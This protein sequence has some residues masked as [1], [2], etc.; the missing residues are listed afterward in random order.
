MPNG[1]SAL[2]YGSTPETSWGGYGSPGAQAEA[3]AEHWG[4]PG[5]YPGGGAWPYGEIR[6]WTPFWQRK[7]PVSKSFF[8]SPLEFWPERIPSPPTQ[9]AGWQLPEWLFPFAWT[10]KGQLGLPLPTTGVPSTLPGW[11][12]DYEAEPSEKQLEEARRIALEDA[13]SAFWQMYATQPYLGAPEGIEQKAA[14]IAF[15]WAKK[16]DFPVQYVDASGK[17]ISAGDIARMRE[18]PLELGEAERTVNVIYALGGGKGMLFGKVKVGELPLPGYLGTSTKAAEEREAETT[19]LAAKGVSDILTQLGKDIS[20][21][22]GKADLAN[23]YNMAI[24]NLAESFAAKRG[25]NLAPSSLDFNRAGAM[26]FDELSKKPEEKAVVYRTLEAMFTQGV[27]PKP[28]PFKPPLDVAKLKRGLVP[29][30]ITLLDKEPWISSIP[31]ATLARLPSDIKEAIS[32]YLASKG[33]TQQEY[34][35]FYSTWNRG[36]QATERWGIPKW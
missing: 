1:D 18:T 9:K 31:P 22:Q 34:Q 23:A 29:Y 14:D 32:E 25:K 2:E 36:G 5:G 6:P 10:E 24:V 3:W 17:P 4:Y 7:Y 27:P 33:V 30:G 19:A 11:T 35:D 8:P 16:Q 13:A 15:D 21:G 26:I 28:K 12:P 20:T